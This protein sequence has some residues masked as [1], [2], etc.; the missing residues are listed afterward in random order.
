MPAHFN[1]LFALA[2]SKNRKGIPSEFKYWLKIGKKVKWYHAK[3]SPIQSREKFEGSVAI[4]R[5]ITEEKLLE[6][7]LKE[8]EEKF[9]IISSSA[10]DGIVIMDDRG[11]VT[12]W[13]KAAEKMFGYK[14][15]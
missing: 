14:E 9:K 4:V 13:N 3:L 11:N 5:D 12:Y 10:Q 8:S 2:F 6:E 15:R 7:S 1:K